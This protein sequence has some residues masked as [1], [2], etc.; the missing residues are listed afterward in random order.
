MKHIRYVFQMVCLN[1]ELHGRPHW[2][3]WTSYRM[4]GK[5][6]KRPGVSKHE[7]LHIPKYVVCLDSIIIE[8]DQLP[9]LEIL[10][11]RWFIVD[12]LSR[13]HLKIDDHW[14]Y[15]PL[16]NSKPLK[17]GGSFLYG[18]QPIF[19]DYVKFFGC[20]IPLPFWEVATWW[21][22]FSLRQWR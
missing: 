5:N 4:R 17:I 6:W 20:T 2:N 10:I 11:G 8:P 21:L 9:T 15:P 3:T 1:N 18:F 13:L 19:R 14:K 7:T 22:V 12:S 16:T